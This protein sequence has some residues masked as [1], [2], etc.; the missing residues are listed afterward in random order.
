M[1]NNF[2]V[3]YFLSLKR[4]ELILYLRARGVVVNNENHQ[5]LAERAYWAEKLG[6]I[7]KLSDREAETAIENAKGS[8]LI[9]D[10]GMISLPRPESLSSGWEAS[11]FSLPD[12]TRDHIDSYIKTG[13]LY[14]FF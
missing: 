3:R 8:K 10:G 1:D 4:D 12:T 2:R 5:S 7:A 6:L 13:K 11:P 9:L 14:S